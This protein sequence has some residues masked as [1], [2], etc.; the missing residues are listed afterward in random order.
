M[1]LDAL[2]SLVDAWMPLMILDSFLS[3]FF[4]FLWV[5]SMDVVPRQLL[6]PSVSEVPVNAKAPAVR[7]TAP[8]AVRRAAECIPERS[9]FGFIIEDYSKEDGDRI[10]VHV[11]VRHARSHT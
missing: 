11:S 5:P 10:T 6:T 7:G 1:F 2:A 3:F 8:C 4:F 9:G